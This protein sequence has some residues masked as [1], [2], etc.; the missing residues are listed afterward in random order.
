[1]AAR[2]QTLRVATNFPVHNHVTRIYIFDTKQFSIN[3]LVDIYQLI[4]QTCLLLLFT[5]LL[6]MLCVCMS[7]CIHLCLGCSDVARD[8]RDNIVQSN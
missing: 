4:S 7:D 2:G 3:F 6:Y 1:M 5:C 8:G